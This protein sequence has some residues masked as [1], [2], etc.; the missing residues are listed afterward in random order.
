MLGTRYATE[1]APR[2]DRAFTGERVCFEYSRSPDPNDSVGKLRLYSVI[3]EP[4]LDAGGQVANVIVVIFEITDL[5]RSEEA[6]R[7]SEARLRGIYERAIAGIAIVDSE[8]NLES[9]NPALCKMLGYEQQELL[10]RHFSILVHPDDREDRANSD[11][12]NLQRLRSGEVEYFASESRYAHKDGHPVWVR[13]VVSTLPSEAGKPD[14]VFSL[15]IDI[16]E[17]KQAAEALAESEQRFR[18]VMAATG[19]GVWDWSVQSGDVKHNAQWCRLLDLDDSYLEHPIQAFL[20]LI[21]D[22]DREKVED[23]IKPSLQAGKPYFSEH[24]MRRKDGSYV[25][26]Q[27]RGNVVERGPDGQALRMV[28]S[29]VE[30]TYRKAAEVRQAKLLADLQTSERDARQQKA[31]LQSIFECTPD[32]MVLTDLNRIIININPAFSAMFGYQLS[33]LRGLPARSIYASQADSDTVAEHIEAGVS[34]LIQRS[35]NCMRRNGEVFPV[36]MTGAKLLGQDGAITGYLGVLRDVTFE[37]KRERALREKQRLEALGR[38]T[39]GIAHDFN[40]LLTVISGNIQLVDMDVDD[41]RL[42]RHLSEAQRATEMGAR[43]NQRL[44]TFARQRK[45]DPQSINLN[46]LVRSVLDLVNRSVGE[47]IRVLTDLKAMPGM[48][49]IDASEMENAILNLALNARDA[50]QHGGQLL[51]ERQSPRTS[52]P[53][54]QRCLAVFSPASMCGSPY[55]TRASECTPEV[56]AR[57]FEPFFTT[58]DEGKGTGLGLTTIHGFVRQS[59]GHVM[60]YSEVDRGTTVNIYLPSLPER[61]S[62]EPLP[63]ALCPATTGRGETILLVEDNFAVRQVT[64]ESDL[65]QRVADRGCFTHSTC[66]ASIPAREAGLSLILDRNRQE[67]AK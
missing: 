23:A 38:L 63:A 24:R 10:G 46:D 28:G 36:E 30:I 27:D 7:A 62:A 29:I 32:G 37:Q 3:F 26:V 45:L 16:S 53:I 56:Q 61:Q 5:R 52:M 66:A 47:S 9:C 34:G 59:G 57:A 22:D 8:G 51:V 39:G 42:K 31:L 60:L 65:R 2:L 54:W 67:A 20:D 21:H 43:L 1:I 33:D 49:R 13:K 64:C 6:L 18:H 25:W 44:M 12:E 19:D 50:M 48:V 58:K 14:N 55:P 41:G 11:R 4:Q 40:N 17:S 35:L 15:S